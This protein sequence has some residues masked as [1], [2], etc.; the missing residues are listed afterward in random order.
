MKN[1]WRS[2]AA[3]CALVIGVYAYTAHSSF[4]ETVSANAADSYYNLL[5][6]GFRAGQLNLKK[7]VPPG[8]I[9]LADPYDSAANA[10]F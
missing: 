2:L 4:L 1:A 3:V 8:L 7:A 9:Q 10:R 5:V 6:Q